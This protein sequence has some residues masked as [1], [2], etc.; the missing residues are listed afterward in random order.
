MR[1]HPPSH[2]VAAKG[3][4]AGVNPELAC[5]GR[6]ADERDHRLGILQRMREPETAAA[7]PRASIVYEDR[8]PPCSTHC[9]RQIEIALGA[10][11]AMEEHEGRVRP[12]A[13]RRVDDAVDNGAAARNMNDFLAS[14][15]S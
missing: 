5:I 12:R 2:A 1:R 6:I 9:L 10:R 4:A 14:G 15:M 13:R 7:A 3:D 11:Q 8:V